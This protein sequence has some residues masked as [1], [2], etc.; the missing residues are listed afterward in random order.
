[1]SVRE[2]L[3]VELG[4]EALVGIGVRL[5]EE[6]RRRRLGLVVVKIDECRWKC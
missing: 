1:M 5:V 4:V 2:E 3:K 6:N